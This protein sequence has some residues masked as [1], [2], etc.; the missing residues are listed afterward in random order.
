MSRLLALLAVL[1]ASCA[2]HAAE[3]TSSSSSSAV[4][5]TL[6]P[7]KPYEACM[8]LGAGDKRRWYWKADG[9]V[10]FN[11]SFHDGDTVSYAVK[12]DRMRGDG[13]TFAA[14][15]AHDY[16]WS[17]RASKPTRLEAKID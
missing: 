12:R 17:W 4:A 16:C 13:G 7:G 3:T 8:S 1:A 6:E 10:D 5:T 15:A 14:K 9:P 11:I 2:L